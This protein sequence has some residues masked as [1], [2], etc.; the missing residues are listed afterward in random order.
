[1]FRWIPF[2]MVRVTAFLGVGILAA[3][4]FPTVLHL[5]GST[6]INALLL[7]I[8]AL[9]VQLREEPDRS[10]AIGIVGLVTISFI[11]YTLV[12]MH[13]ASNDLTHFMHERDSIQSYIAIVRSVPQEKTKSWKVEIEVQAIR[14]ESWQAADGKVLLYVSSDSLPLQWN[15]GDQVLIKHAPVLIKEPANP[16]E[17]DYKRFLSFKNIY[18][19][20]FVKPSEVQWLAPPKR[21]GFIYY[22]HRMR[23]WAS[24]QINRYVHDTQSQA[25]ASALVLGVT[26]G[27]DNDLLNAY[28][29][30]GAMHVLAVSGLHVGIIYALLLFLLKP[31][32][33]FRGSAWLTAGISLVCL[34]SFAFITGLSPSVL[35]AVTMFSFVALAKPFAHRTNIYNTLAAS[36]FVLLLYNP[37]LIMSVGFQLSYLAVLGIV[38]LQRPIYNGWEV[39]SRVGDWIWQITCVSLAAQI[40][41]FSLGLLYFHQFPVYFLVSN[42]FVIPL[43]TG[44]LSLGIILLCFSWMTPLAT[45]LG[46]MLSALIYLLNQT[47]F[48]TEKL[49][50]SLINDIYITTWQCW[51]LM[52][53]LLGVLMVFEWR[54]LSGLYV[55]L[56]CGIGF[57]TIQWNQYLTEKTEK[58]W[59]VYA[60]RGHRAMD[61]ISD[62]QARFVADTSLLKDPEK[63]RFHIRPNRLMHG[64]QLIRTDSTLATESNGLAY[65]WWQNKL[66]T[67]IDCSAVVLP[68]QWNT[69][70]LV[71]SCN[72]L[73]I[74]KIRKEQIGM[75]VL[76]GSNTQNYCNK[77]IKFAKEKELPMYSV[78]HQGAFILT[79]SK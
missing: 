37:Y 74:R 60:I 11:G 59:V 27:L 53:M 29:A 77:L 6:F 52:G 57:N 25:I 75:I 78:L 8:Y 34:W 63:I 15:Y 36:A 42:L 24:S 22:S 4:E 13:T 65:T 56:L 58:Q 2:A 38:Y 79:E 39:K 54:T 62:G 12:L 69:D 16:G 9:L 51:L 66:I 40:A 1:M 28:A 70:Y 45:V 7:S 21:K 67:Q 10:S 49:P 76:D 20:H 17:F 33:K 32:G 46:K 73:D 72:A 19:Q 64:V 48:L 23:A 43:S 55:A 30:S 68:E 47:V 44:V 41:T 61:F 14:T 18:H 5:D 71:V 3:I 50:L 26:D 31:F 35:R